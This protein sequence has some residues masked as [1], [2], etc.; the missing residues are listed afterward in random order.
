MEIIYSVRVNVENMNVAVRMFYNGM[1]AQVCSGSEPR[2]AK[3]YGAAMC[4]WVTAGRGTSLANTNRG[5]W[6]KRASGFR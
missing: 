4:E 6:P 5:L 2:G 3:V 1:C